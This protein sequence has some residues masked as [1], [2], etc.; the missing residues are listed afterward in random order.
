MINNQRVVLP[1]SSSKNFKKNGR[2]LIPALKI[3]PQ[4][5][6]GQLSGGDGTKTH[7]QKNAKSKNGHS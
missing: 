7:L 5:L 2:F 3:T 4:M 1:K 6:L